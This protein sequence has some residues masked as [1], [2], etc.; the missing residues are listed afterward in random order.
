MV[1]GSFDTAF[2]L[3][4]DQVGVVN[5]EP[6][7]AHFMEQFAR[8]KASLSALPLL[9]SL[10]IHL[11]RNWKEAGPKGGLPARA[12][13]LEDLVQELQSA[14]KL[15]TGG[16]FVDAKDKFV[17]VK[18]FLRSNMKDIFTQKNTIVSYLLKM[19]VFHQYES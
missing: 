8:S 4:H 3:L 7:K 1:A 19:R 16:K 6:Y 14:Y 17:K 2:K 10:Q 12:I 9:P 15:T 13:K 11:H 5:F 18:I